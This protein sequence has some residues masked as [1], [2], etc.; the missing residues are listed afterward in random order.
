MSVVR[1]EIN[2]NTNT[3]LVGVRTVKTTLEKYFISSTEVENRP[4]N[5][6]PKFIPNR[7][8]GTCAPA[9]TRTRV[10]LPLVFGVTCG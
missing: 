9:D 6:V 8:A 10:I 2:R 4:G 5:F 1:Q 7:N 3:Q